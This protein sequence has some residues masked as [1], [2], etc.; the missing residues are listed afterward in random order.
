[1]RTS[2]L[3]ILLVLALGCAPAPEGSEERP[4]ETQPAVP[5][6]PEA[7]S[8]AV[9]TL[10]K[11]DVPDSG[12]VAMVTQNRSDPPLNQ[13]QVQLR[14]STD[15]RF[16]VE[17]IQLVW[18]GMSPPTA[19]AGHNVVA[20]QTIDFPVPLV[21]AMCAGNGGVSSMPDVSQAYAVLAFD[22][23]A[24]EEVPVYD[25]QRVLR[26]LYLKSCERQLIE[27][28]VAIRWENVTATQLDGVPIS[29]ADLVLERSGAPAGVAIVNVSQTI[30]Y[31]PTPAEPVDG[32]VAELKRGDIEVRTPFHFF[33]SRCDA[34]SLAEVKQ[35]FQFVAMVDLGD[36]VLR[37]YTVTPAVEDQPTIRSAG[38]ERCEVLG[39]TGTLG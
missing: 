4:S 1:M 23:G 15:R 34:H 25:N 17:Q 18:D 33:E 39:E 31:R 5:A 7:A 30:P 12:L 11:I 2:L 19:T 10:P 16:R 3:G 13:F 29:S 24:S 22:D 20:G 38:F 35:P 14:N 6:W 9:E 37:P 36:G 8:D 26:R 28:L 21:P 27:R 32:A